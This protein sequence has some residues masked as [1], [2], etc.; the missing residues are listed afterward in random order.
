M[1]EII[2]VSSPHF[3]YKTPGLRR[4]CDEVGKFEVKTDSPKLC[5]ETKDLYGLYRGKRVHLT[6]FRGFTNLQFSDV[7]AGLFRQRGWQLYR[8]L[9]LVY[10][11]L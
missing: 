1:G 11:Y 9:R 4:G 6:V 5:K 10:P 3:Y 2:W 7:N 8:L